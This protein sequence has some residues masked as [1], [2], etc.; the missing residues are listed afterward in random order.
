MKIVYSYTESP[1]IIIPI[2]TIKAISSNGITV[3]RP[4]DFKLIPFS[5][6][7]SHSKDNVSKWLDQRLVVLNKEC[8][9]L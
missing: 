9:S 3:T 7:L 6:L 4:L 8:H 5:R 1:L 2:T